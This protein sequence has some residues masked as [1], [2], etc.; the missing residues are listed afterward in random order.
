MAPLVQAGDAKHVQMM[1]PCSARGLS[2]RLTRSRGS[3]R[4]KAGGIC[5]GDLSTAAAGVAELSAHIIAP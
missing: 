5:Q 3:L 1:L 4:A 2:P